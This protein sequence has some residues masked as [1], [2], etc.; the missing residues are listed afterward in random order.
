MIQDYLPSEAEI[1]ELNLEIVETGVEQG[2]N[3]SVYKNDK[4][5][6]ATYQ[7][8]FDVMEPDNSK[9]EFVLQHPDKGIVFIGKLK[10]FDELKNQLERCQLNTE[11]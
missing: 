1:Q 10:S 2:F 7:K 4:F 6:M 3:M 8:N 5:H 9:T 11:K